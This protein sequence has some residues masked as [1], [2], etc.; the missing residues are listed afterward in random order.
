MWLV[1]KKFQLP[2]GGTWYGQPP[3]NCPVPGLKA[4]AWLADP[5]ALE[6]VSAALLL[7]PLLVL[8]AALPVELD[9]AL[10]LLVD[11][12]LDAV[13]EA[14]LLPVLDA[15]FVDAA[16]ALGEE[17]AALEAAEVFADAVPEALP[18]LVVVEPELPQAASRLDAPA[19]TATRPI[20]R[21]A[22]RRESTAPMI[23]PSAE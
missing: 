19:A 2:V 16:L 3:L 21:S 7:V 17:V 10:A 14:L 22:L 15:A 1:T 6:E 20:T 18:L 4:A 13:P 11:A 12:A 9:A 23:F 8:A 5:L